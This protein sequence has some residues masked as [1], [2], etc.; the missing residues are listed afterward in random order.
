MLGATQWA[1]IDI[2]TGR[3]RDIPEEVFSSFPLVS[4]SDQELKELGIKTILFKAAL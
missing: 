4:S 2:E 3:G 1:F